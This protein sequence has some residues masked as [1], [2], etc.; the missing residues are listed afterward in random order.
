MKL[1]LPLL[2]NLKKNGYTILIAKWP[3]KNKMYFF[4]PIKWDVPEFF[5]E[6][7]PDSFKDHGILLI[8]DALRLDAEDLL[9]HQVIFP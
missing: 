6:A 2:Q 9:K 7:N 1:T 4:T 3:L 8:K 5:Y